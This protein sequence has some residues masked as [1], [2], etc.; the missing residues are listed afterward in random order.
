LFGGRYMTIDFRSI[1]RAA[2]DALPVLI[3][4][5]LPDGRRCGREYI[6]RN[7]TRNDRHSGSFSIAIVTGAWAD[8]AT[9]DKGGDVVALFPYLRG[10]RQADAARELARLLQ[11]PS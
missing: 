3:Q 7:P 9:G 5:W 11:V 2:L 4:R 10:I 1:N 6:A 8:F